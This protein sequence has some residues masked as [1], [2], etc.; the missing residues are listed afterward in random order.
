MDDIVKQAMAKWL[1]VPDCYGWLGLD[2]R[3]NWYMRDDQAQVAGSFDSGNPQSKGSRLQHEKLID[4][5]GRNYAA[6]AQGQW[7]FQNGPQ[8]V[9]VELEATP[10]VWRLAADFS[11]SAHTG[12]ATQALRCMHDE[13]GWVYLV[14]PLGFGLVHTQDVP[15]A[16][17]AI[18]SGEWALESVEK[19]A[20]PALFTYVK[21]PQATKTSI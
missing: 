4:F 18:E 12:Q 17:Q 20:L 9:Y 10:W 6:D 2:A 7:Y 11:V 21:S 15:T 3:G 19:A 1:N 13:N 14:T 16:A 8:R 5:I